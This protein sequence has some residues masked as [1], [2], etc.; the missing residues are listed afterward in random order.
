[1]RAAAFSGDG[2]EVVTANR[3]GRATVWSA[4]LSS[5]L[6]RLEGLARARVTRGLTAD[7]R[8]TYLGQ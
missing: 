7:E 2:K 4:E 8:R 6:E 1:M 5:S 3:G